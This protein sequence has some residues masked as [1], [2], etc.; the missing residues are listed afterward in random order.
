MKKVIQVMLVNNNSYQNAEI[1]KSIK[2]AG[3]TN[4]VK[5]AVNGGHGIL[6]LHHL[7]LSEKINEGVVLVLLNLNTPMVDGFEFLNQFKY[8]RDLRKE[9]IVIVVL[10]KNLPEDQ[11]AK[12]EKLGITHFVPLP[13]CTENLKNIL[14]STEQAQGSSSSALAA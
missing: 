3:I 4:D 7:Q 12:A 1:E 5:M 14:V 13:C 11:K 8:S 2:S 10:D 6:H 9:N